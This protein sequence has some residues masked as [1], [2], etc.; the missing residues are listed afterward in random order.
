MK[1]QTAKLLLAVTAILIPWD[2]RAYGN[3]VGWGFTFSFGKYVNTTGVFNTT[4][5]IDVHSPISIVVSDANGNQFR[6]IFREFELIE[7]FGP[8][9]QIG[10]YV[11]GLAS[12]LA[13]I[14][15]LYTAYLLYSREGDWSVTQ[16]RAVG[17]LFV[18]AGAV[19]VLSRFFLYDFLLVSAADQPNWFS[20]PVGAL[21]VIVVGGV[22][23]YWG[24]LEA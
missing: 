20:V 19:F 1:K 5:G 7:Q 3:D 12:L 9:S 16:Y 6:T 2:L 4:A 21:Y 15:L 17:A 14:A 11:W 18:G 24:R 22:F 8:G 13:V 23:L 10:L